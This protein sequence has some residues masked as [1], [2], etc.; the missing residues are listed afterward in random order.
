MAL[1]YTMP[2]S[3]SSICNLF[4]R[5]LVFLNENSSVRDEIQL[6]ERV[7]NVKGS[8]EIEWQN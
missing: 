4:M 1:A 7:D 2:R 5:P 8:N 3:T 6:I